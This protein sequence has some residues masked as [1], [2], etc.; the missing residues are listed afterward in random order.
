MNVLGECYRVLFEQHGPQLF[1]SPSVESVGPVAQRTLRHCEKIQA[2]LHA[3]KPFKVRVQGKAP[4]C[5]GP[6]TLTMVPVTCPQLEIIEFLLQPLC[7]ED[8]QLPE[9][10]LV[11]PTLVLA[12]KGLLH[13]PVVNVG[14]SEV[15]L[16]PRRAIGT[17][18]VVRA[19]PVGTR[20]VVVEP[21]WEECCAFISTQ[22][23]TPDSDVH[24]PSLP[25]F[26][27]LTPQQVIQAKALFAKY[28]GIFSRG[29]GDLGCT[30]LIAHEIPLVDNIPVCQP[31]RRIPPSQYENSMRSHSTATGEPS[32]KGKL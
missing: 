21:A 22:E 15:W 9:G 3:S 18:Q 31:Y 19:A 23:V 4:V 13:A 28:E 6:G 26:E 24:L 30:S 32:Y 12:K 16:S 14:S 2:V 10:L 25:D 7:I 20:S 5:L 29:D 1:H 8:G 17:V 27:G 11:S